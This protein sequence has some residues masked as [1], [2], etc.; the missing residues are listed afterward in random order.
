MKAGYVD[1]QRYVESTLGVPQGGGVSPLLSNIYLHELDKF[2]EKLIAEYDEPN[3]RVSRHNPEYYK[4]KKEGNVE[5]LKK[6]P[7]MI[8]DETTGLRVRYNRFA[9]D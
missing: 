8:R 4:H 7:T 2:V 6:T 3:K 5:K 1:Q 9:D